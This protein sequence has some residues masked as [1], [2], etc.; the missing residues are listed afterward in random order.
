[1]FFAPNNWRQ[2]SNLSALFVASFFFFLRVDRCPYAD[3]RG[4]FPGRIRARS[5]SEE[6]HFFV[7]FCFCFCARLSLAFAKTKLR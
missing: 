5:F 6:T 3:R 7:F 4:K 2:P 1:M